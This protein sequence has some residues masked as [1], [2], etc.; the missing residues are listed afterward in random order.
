MGE[1]MND[2]EMLDYALGRHE[3]LDVRGIEIELE[4][5]PEALERFERLRESLHRLLDDGDGVEPPLGL[6]QRTVA[7]VAHH[8][9]H[10]TWREAI[11]IRL[12]FRWADLAVAASI[13]LAGIL[14]LAPA[15]ERSRDRMNQAGCVFNLQQLGMSLN[16]Y[17]TM[18]PYLPYPPLHRPDAHA[19]MFAA[20]LHDAGVLN[21]PAVLDCPC[22]GVRP[23][24]DL[25]LASF[26]QIDRIR[27]TDP[28]EYRRLLEFDYAYNVGYLHDSGLPGPIEALLASRVPVL[29]DQPNHEDFRTIKEGN[30]PNH[31]GRGQNVLFGD[32]SVRWFTNRRVSPLDADVFLNNENLPLPGLSPVDSVLVPSMMPIQPR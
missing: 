11:P 22:N 7:F 30:S 14:T 27:R 8:R 25:H 2:H 1:A 23:R 3:A 32:G 21:N 18:H 31:A 29:A 12:P 24:G 17:S 5:N 19:G 15:I 4:D 20:I 10:P 28:A 16:Q 6:A 13:F 9:R 26:D